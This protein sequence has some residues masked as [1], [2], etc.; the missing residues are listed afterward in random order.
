MKFL[1]EQIQVTAE[2][3]DG[4]GVDFLSLTYDK[5]ILSKKYTFG[6]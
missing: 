3:D 1:T 6:K 2:A 5:E 4:E